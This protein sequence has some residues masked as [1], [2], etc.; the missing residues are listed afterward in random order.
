MNPDDVAA[1][2]RRA[3]RLRD[4]APLMHAALIKIHRTMSDVASGGARARPTV[5]QLNEMWA[6]ARAALDSARGET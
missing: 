1:N 3:E 5:A 4:A 6:T 2:E